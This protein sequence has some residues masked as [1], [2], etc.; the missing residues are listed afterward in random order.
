MIHRMVQV[1]DLCCFF[2]LIVEINWIFLGVRDYIH[3][4]DVAIGH[5]AAMK[6]FEENC[7]FKVR[8]NEKEKLNW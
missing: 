4:V 5:T 3:V 7:G 2:F 6:K 8:M 1:N